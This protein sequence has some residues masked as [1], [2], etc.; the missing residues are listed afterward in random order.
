[1]RGVLLRV[2]N[3]NRHV[4]EV[5]RRCGGWAAFIRGRVKKSSNYANYTNKSG[6]FGMGRFFP[7]FSTHPE[8]SVFIRFIR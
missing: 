3:K 6:A 8:L 1:M 7:H 5:L 4:E 2:K